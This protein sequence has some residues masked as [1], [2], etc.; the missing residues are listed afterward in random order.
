MRFKKF[1]N[2]NGTASMSD[3]RGPPSAGGELARELQGTWVSS[4]S[5]CGSHAGRQE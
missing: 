2:T 3:G 1:K 4:V 5:S